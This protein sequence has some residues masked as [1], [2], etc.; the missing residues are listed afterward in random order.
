MFTDYIFNP[1]DIVIA[2]VAG[3]LLVAVGH[4]AVGRSPA[5]RAIAS[6]L[7]TF[8]VVALLALIGMRY[9]RDGTMDLVVIATLVS[10]LSAISLARGLTGGER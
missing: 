9:G 8:A 5:D 1:L 7:L 3:S 2:V 4:I 10:F 6:D